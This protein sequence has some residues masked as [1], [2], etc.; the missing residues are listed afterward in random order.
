MIFVERKE[1]FQ[2]W[3]SAG[4]GK[5]DLMALARNGPTIGL[6]EPR[7]VRG[8]GDQAVLANNGAI[9]SKSCRDPGGADNFTLAL[10]MAEG[11]M[12]PGRERDV[13]RFIRAYMPAT[14]KSL[15]CLPR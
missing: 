11:P 8:I 6:F 10:K 2:L 13:E 3:F 9:A 5:P 4:G 14:V 12:K 15:N 7:P 1:V